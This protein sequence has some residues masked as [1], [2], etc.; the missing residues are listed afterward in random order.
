MVAAMK[1]FEVAVMDDLM[2][3]VPVR[4]LRC[5]EEGAA[6]VLWR[7]GLAW[8]FL[9]RSRFGGVHPRAVDGG[10]RAYLLF[11][12]DP[13]IVIDILFFQSPAGSVTFPM[14]GVSLAWF[15]VAELK[16]RCMPPRCR[17]T[18]IDDSV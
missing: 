18:R 12:Y 8:R 14:T 13:V 10:Y 4:R 9:E 16:K 1:Q 3:D 15:R 6:A 17:P 2:R 11:S 5:V 7:C